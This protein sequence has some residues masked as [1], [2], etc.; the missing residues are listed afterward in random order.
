MGQT[1]EVAG[2]GAAERYAH[3][4]CGEGIIQ[5]DMADVDSSR[6]LYPARHRAVLDWDSINKLCEQNKD[7]DKFLQDVRIDFTGGKIHRA[8]FD[9]IHMDIEKYIKEKLKS[10]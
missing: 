3:K 5:L 7:F 2:A 1:A 6:A 4:R 8:E 9:E 10:S